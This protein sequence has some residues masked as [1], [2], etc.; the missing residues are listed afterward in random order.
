MFTKSTTAY[1][2]FHKC[3]QCAI[4]KSCSRKQMPT[5]RQE[6]YNYDF[7]WVAFTF[8]LKATF[9]DLSCKHDVVLIRQIHPLIKR[10]KPKRK[11]KF[12]VH[13]FYKMNI[14]HSFYAV[15]NEL[16]GDVM[17]ILRFLQDMLTTHGVNKII[18]REKRYRFSQ[19]S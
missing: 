18:D 4:P 8:L 14:K 15:A 11:Q 10:N 5:A 19:S 2:Y 7:S 1:S 13:L 16:I 12:C 6:Q 3:T 17:E 9:P